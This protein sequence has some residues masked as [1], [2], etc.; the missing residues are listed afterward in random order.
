LIL[1]EMAVKNDPEVIE[2]VA[3]LMEHSR[4][5]IRHHPQTL[6]PTPHTL[7]PNLQTP[8]PTP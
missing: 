4:A 1:D 3:R 6:N 8:N 7:N 2:L 5:E